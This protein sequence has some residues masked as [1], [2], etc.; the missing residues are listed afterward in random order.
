M[1]GEHP[2]DHGS[3]FTVSDNR[4]TLRWLE[5]CI[6]SAH[7]RRKKRLVELLEVVKSEIIFDMELADQQK[8]HLIEQPNENGWC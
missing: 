5:S 7:F 8:H 6:E 1:S 2:G 4:V 3:H